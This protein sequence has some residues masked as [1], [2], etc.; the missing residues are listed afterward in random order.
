MAKKLTL[1]EIEVG[2]KSESSTLREMYE[3][4]VEN[5]CRMST[6][7]RDAAIMSEVVIPNGGVELFAER[8]K[9]DYLEFS[10]IATTRYGSIFVMADLETEE[11]R[12]E[13]VKIWLLVAAQAIVTIALAAWIY[14]VNF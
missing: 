8:V 10:K 3:L 14:H 7:Q 4:W 9:N 12:Q 5:G 1:E 11:G 2:M 6:L 13:N